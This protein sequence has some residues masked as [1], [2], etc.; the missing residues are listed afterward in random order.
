MVLTAGRA[1]LPTHFFTHNQTSSIL[2]P[3]RTTVHKAKFAARKPDKKSE[4]R[5]LIDLFGF[6]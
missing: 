2:Q 4:V 1:A 6:M 5:E 3:K